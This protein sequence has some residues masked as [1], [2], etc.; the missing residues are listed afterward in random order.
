MR[1]SLTDGLVCA[2]VGV[3]TI[4][5][6]PSAAGGGRVHGVQDAPWLDG[7]FQYMVC[8]RT[9]LLPPSCEF[10]SDGAAGR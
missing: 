1:R 2:V 7:L 3:M 5:R 8:T 9:S 4:R 10:V 6:A